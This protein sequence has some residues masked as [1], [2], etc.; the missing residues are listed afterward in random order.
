MDDTSEPARAG[1]GRVACLGEP[2]LR[3]SAP[4]GELLLQSARLLAHFGGA[5][6]N[7]AVSL[8]CLGDDARFLGALP[9]NPLGQSFAGELRRHGVELSFAPRRPGR[10]GLYFLTPGAVLR[11]SEVLYDRAGSAFAEAGPDAYD[12]DGALAGCDWLHLS[13]ITPAVSAQAA[14]AALEAVRAAVRLGVKVSFD[15]NYRA[16]MWAAWGGEPRPV[17]HELV[18]HASLLFGDHRDVGLVLGGAFDHA[19]PMERRAAAAAAAFEAFPRLERM[20]GTLRAEPSVRRQGVAAFLATREDVALAPEL[21]LEGVVDRIGTGDAFAAGV[22]HGLIGGMTA[23]RC[24]RFAL[25]ASAF[26]HSVLGDFSPAQA[27]DIE[28]A[29]ADAGL[30]VRR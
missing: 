7:V 17:L 10:M 14:E 20:A 21:A 29:L 16:R 19:D 28:A 27:A 25:A 2:L 23:E 13:G 8:A 9:D 24:L 12:F 15:G 26:K 3:L 18:G 6:A 11:P 4:D 5:E 22:L 30:A 1:G